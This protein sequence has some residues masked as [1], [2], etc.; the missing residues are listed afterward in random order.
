MDEL[1]KGVQHMTPVHHRGYIL[2]R[3]KTRRVAVT[4]D[5]S[6]FMSLPKWIKDRYKQDWEVIRICIGS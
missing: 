4:V 1:C 2:L 5:C 3:H 6:W